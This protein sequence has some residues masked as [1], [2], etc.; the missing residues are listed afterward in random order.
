[1][2][3]DRLCCPV[4]FCHPLSFNLF[5][6]LLLEVTKNRNVV[7]DTVDVTVYVTIEFYHK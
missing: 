4:T 2:D 7:E 3:G 6:R 1:M 5:G